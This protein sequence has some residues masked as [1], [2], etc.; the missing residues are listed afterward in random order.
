MNF[1]DIQTII[2]GKLKFKGNERSE[3]ALVKSVINQAYVNFAQ[4]DCIIT[5]K[6][7]LLPTVTL[8]LPTD[9]LVYHSLYVTV[10]VEDLTILDTPETPLTLTMFKI[11]RHYLEVKANKI[12]IRED[13][14]LGLYVRSINLVYG[15]K[16]ADLVLDGDVPLIQAIYHQGLM[17]YALFVITDDT[18]YYDLYMSI[19]NSIPTDN[20]VADYTDIIDVL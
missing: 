3:M 17:Y 18:K 12:I 13:L 10:S 6:E 8:D 20:Y 19:Y 5:E 11:P 9:F 16:P 15:S 4:K 2:N 14:L 7:Y 1:K